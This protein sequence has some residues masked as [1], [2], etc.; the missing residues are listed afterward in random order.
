MDEPSKEEII[1]LVNS[2]FKVNDFTKTEFS[3]EFE[4]GDLAFKTKI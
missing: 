3:L 1:A 4:I 2:M